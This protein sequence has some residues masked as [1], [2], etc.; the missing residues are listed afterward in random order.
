MRLTLS[1]IYFGQL[2]VSVGALSISVGHASWHGYPQPL[3]TAYI[4]VAAGMVYPLLTWYLRGPL[5]EPGN[6]VSRDDAATVTPEGAPRDSSPHAGDAGG[7]RDGHDACVGA[8][9]NRGDPPRLPRPKPRRFEKD[10]MRV[11]L[12]EA[13]WG[14]LFTFF[15][16]LQ[17]GGDKAHIPGFPIPFLTECC[18]LATGLGLPLIAWFLRRPFQ[19]LDIN[20]R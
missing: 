3:W 17:L 5:Q 9:V 15:G 12:A 13:C 11:T 19:Q 10:M 16:V 8:A 14:Q 6:H 1:E 7:E 2:F 18:I 4:L 20:K